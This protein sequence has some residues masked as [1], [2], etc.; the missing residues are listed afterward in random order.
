MNNIIKFTMITLA[1]ALPCSASAGDIKPY[2]GS[3][4]GTYIIGN[5]TAGN[6]DYVVGGYASIGLEISPYLAYE[7]RAG[8]TAQANNSISSFGTDFFVS[9]LI[10]PQYMLQGFN[11]YALLGASTIK[12]WSQDIGKTKIT[13]TNTSFS[14]GGGVE[15]S[16]TDQFTLGVEAMILDNRRGFNPYSGNFTGAATGNLR[17]LF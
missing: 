6:G 1:L 14:F 9:Y 10:K 7:L 2:I 3:G 15:T 5:G 8:T 11:V 16:V 12:S 17:Y 13:K 4:I